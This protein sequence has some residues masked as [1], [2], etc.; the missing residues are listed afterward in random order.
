M[1]TRINNYKF[2][3]DRMLSF[4][5]DTGPYLQYAHAR[6]CSIAR[7]TG[8]SHEQLEKADFALLQEPHAIDLLRSMASFPDMVLH[9]YRSNQEPSTI[10]TYLFKLTHQLSSSY[11]VLQVVGAKEGP[12]T[13]LARAA[14]YEGA[15]QVLKN[16]MMLLGL[17]PVQRM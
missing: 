3:L 9:T 4:E 1:R 12:E 6:L 13:T 16:G 10:V 2:D 8:L 7:R 17:S 11:D 15:R 5:G 14:L